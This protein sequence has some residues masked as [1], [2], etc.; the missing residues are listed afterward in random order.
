MEQQRKGYCE[1][2]RDKCDAV[3]NNMACPLFGTLTKRSRDGKR[4]VKHCNDPVAKGRRNRHKGDQ[5]AGAVRRA[6]NLTG[7]NSRHEELWGGALRIEIKAGK[8]V[9]PIETRFRLAEMQSE[10][11]R[12]L[13]DIRPFVMAAMPDGTSDGIILCRLS[14]FKQILLSLEDLQKEAGLGQ[15]KEKKT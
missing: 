8:Q 10:Q 2:N 7:A 14:V 5:K 12:P 6:L 1:G 15:P 9:Q 3:L 4:R 13:G 11:Q